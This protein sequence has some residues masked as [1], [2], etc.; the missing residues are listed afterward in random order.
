MPAHTTI[1]VRPRR[2]AA[3]AVL[4]VLLAG[5]QAPPFPEQAR[6]VN[7]AASACPDWRS[8]RL[9]HP[10]DAL[11]G[12]PSP[13]EALSLGC[14]NDT[15]LTRMVADPADLR[16]G[17]GTGPAHAPSAV[18]AVQRYDKNETTPLPPP[19]GTFGGM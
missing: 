10:I 19:S 3:A 2:L 14:V 1:R 5:C 12:N 18:G 15:N 13:A 4:T 9:S 6:P 7:G 16:G 11:L 17:R 8:A